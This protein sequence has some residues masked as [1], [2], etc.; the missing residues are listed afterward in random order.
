MM[1]QF[2]IKLK[3]SYLKKLRKKINNFKE[4]LIRKIIG[5]NYKYDML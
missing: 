3:A 1:M 4:N 5:I 2:R